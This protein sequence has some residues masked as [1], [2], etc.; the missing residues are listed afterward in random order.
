[1]TR[2]IIDPEAR[3][4]IWPLQNCIKTYIFGMTSLSEAAYLSILNFKAAQ[5]SLKY[6]KLGLSQNGLKKLINLPASMKI[7]HELSEVS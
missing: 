4:I 2:F 1:M 3:L 5:K 6:W 7:V